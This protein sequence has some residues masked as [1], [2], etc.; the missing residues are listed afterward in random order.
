MG[1]W[2]GGT[3]AV[4]LAASAREDTTNE[5]YDRHWNE[6]DEW[7][8][9]QQL[10]SLPATPR[11]V[12]AY[13]GHLADKGTIAAGSLQPYLSAINS[14]HAD[15]G[16]ERPALGH[17]VTSARKGMA[18]AQALCE[19]RDTR[20]PMPATVARDVLRTALRRR[21]ALR[22][23]RGPRVRLDARGLAE[24]LRRR[25]A[26]VLSFVFFGRQDSTT[27][28][29]SCDHGIDANFIW[30]R[31]TEKQKRSQPYR[32]VVRLPLDAPPSNGH[33]SALPD[34]AA[35]GRAYLEARAA[36]G[37]ATPR[38]LLQLPGEPKPTARHMA[39]WVALTLKEEGVSAPAGFAYLGHSLRSGGSSAAE[40]IKVS[41][42]R[43]NW[44][45][46]WSQTGRTRELHYMDPSV[47][48]TAA[49]FELL[50]WLLDGTYSTGEFERAHPQRSRG[51]RV[52]AGR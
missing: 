9:A 49:A 41:R 23:A 27:A 47:L 43:G 10:E 46:G 22:A 37:G 7:C 33:A 3:T 35:L 45:G 40:A 18:R 31:L 5:G 2:S 38:W 29:A 15:Y 51:S 30:L 25:Y 14:R 20:V 34:L 52:R 6:F 50:G 32:R 44:L 36:L 13:V 48:P 4:R 24:Y 1:A 28:L 12:F 17:L 26:F 19:T 21:R 42:F 8:A 39:E 16:F 11:M